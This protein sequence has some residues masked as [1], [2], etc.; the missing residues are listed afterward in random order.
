MQRIR[1]V[2]VKGF[3]KT[4]FVD[5]PGKLCAVI[6]FP[7][8]NFRCP[9]CHNADLVL[10]PEALENIAWE[11]IVAYL[12]RQRG[13]IDGVCVS[14]G[15]PTLQPKLPAVLRFLRQ[16]G[17]QTKL[18]TNGS[19]PAV[20]EQLLQERL[21]D[22]V[23]MDVKTCLDETQ[24]RVVAGVPDMA[25]RVKRSIRLLVGGPVDYEFRTTVVPTLHRS[26]DAV[27]LARELTGAQRLRIQNFHPSPSVLDPALRQVQ[28]FTDDEI[29][30]LQARVNAIL[31]TAGPAAH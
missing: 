31:E 4:S 2:A 16:L 30:G 27:Q 29:A 15:E 19:N 5:W 17:V 23:A 10:R 12:E 22:Y 28:P 9:Y 25:D 6:F 21:L 20:L 11:D 3:I 8:C 1:Q 18:D 24:Y 26:Q 13:W 7:R 14:G